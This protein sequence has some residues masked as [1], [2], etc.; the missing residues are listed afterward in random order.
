LIFQ[1]A[2]HVFVN[3]FPLVSNY[4]TRKLIIQ[5]QVEDAGHFCSRE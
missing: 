4:D 2:Q 5:G 3:L 1:E